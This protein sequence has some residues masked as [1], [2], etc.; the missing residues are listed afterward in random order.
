MSEVVLSKG[1]VVTFNGLPCGLVEDT[2][3]IC[4]TLAANPNELERLL[5]ETDV[6]Q[7]IS[8]QHSQSACAS[9]G[10]ARLSFTACGCLRRQRVNLSGVFIVAWW[11]CSDAFGLR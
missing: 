1:S 9:G 5:S 4:E 8:N 2:K 7:N 3:V 11:P 6:K 10:H